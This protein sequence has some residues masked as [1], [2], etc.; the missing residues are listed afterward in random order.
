MTSLE[1]LCGSGTWYILCLVSI[2]LL[3]ESLRMSIS[4]LNAKNGRGRTLFIFSDLVL[5]F[6]IFVILM[7]CGHFFDIVEPHEVYTSIENAVFSLPW[8]VIAGLEFVAAMIWAL[9]EAEKRQYQSSHLTI[10][11]IRSSIDHLPEGIAIGD[12]K[13]TVLLSNLKMVDLYRKLTGDILSDSRHFMDRISKMAYATEPQLIV[14][15]TEGRRWLFESEIIRPDEEEYQ[16]IIARD[17]TQQ[18]RIID[19]LKDKNE[20]LKDIQK[21]MKAVSDLSADMF[22]AEEQAKA[23]AALHNQLGQ[24]LLMGRYYLKNRSVADPEQVY[25]ITQQMNR[26]LLGEAEDEGKA[27]TDPLTEAVT[28]AGGIGV[29]V[30]MNE[31]VHADMR[32][33]EILSVAII[34]C[35]ANTV[36]HAGGDSLT[37]TCYLRNTLRSRIYEITITNNGTPPKGPVAESGGLFALRKKTESM[38]GEMQTESAPAFRLVIRIPDKN[39][40]NG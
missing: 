18:Y 34:E 13:G 12:M 23:R 9:T 22:V 24:V 40:T 10:N 37:A 7:D 35:A 5:T 32:L 16:Q 21:R 31:D 19:E 15:D 11:A 38:G 20:R 8:I 25:A 6:V 2:F 3:V 1:S 39:G 17:V 4:V 28:M 30:H 36:K 14:V 33:R 29:S 26:I 27:V